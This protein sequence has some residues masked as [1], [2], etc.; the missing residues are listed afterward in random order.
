MAVGDRLDYEDAFSRFADVKCRD[1]LLRAL[2]RTAAELGFDHAALDFIPRRVTGLRPQH[3]STYATQW[4]DECL[5]LPVALI[6]RDPV[7]QHL[8][9][10]V[11]PIVWG[12]SD[13]HT[14]K[15]D[16]VY[17]LFQGYGLG[18]GL[19]ATV[20]GAHGDY[21]C[22]GFSSADT[23]V[24]KSS[25]LTQELGKL[26]LS[27]T[28]AYTAMSGI[29]APSAGGAERV[30][31]TQRELEILRWSRAGKTALDCSQILGIGQATVHF[32]LKNTLQKLDVSTKQQAVL[33]ALEQRLIY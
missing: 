7:L 10:S 5:S 8:D 4:I 32:H 3:V 18:S 1:S 2:T 12:Q 24:T 16:N 21:A 25:D 6:A 22:V 30:K 9:S 28:A 23:R 29:L 17:E 13:Y 33:K 26:L 20:R 11:I 15:L 19:A 14:S 27:A 31:L